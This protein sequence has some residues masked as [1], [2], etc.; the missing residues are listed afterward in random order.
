MMD[1]FMSPN[2]RPTIY[3]MPYRSI[4]PF[5]LTVI[6]L[7]G[8]AWLSPLTGCL[9]RRWRVRY[10][11]MIPQ[12]SLFGAIQPDPHFSTFG[13]RHAYYSGRHFIDVWVWFG[14][15]RLRIWWWMISCHPISYLSYIWCHTGAYFLFGWGLQIFMELYDLPHS[16]DTYQGDDVFVIFTRISHWSLSGAIQLGLHFSTLRCYHASP[17]ERYLLDLWVWFYYGRGWLRPCIW[18]WMIW[19]HLIFRPV[20][21]DA[22]LGHIPLSVDICTSP[23]IRMIILG[24]KIHVRL[25]I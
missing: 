18:W 1:D 17:S 19:G 11:V 9:P 15:R 23:L 13:C 10:L 2:F 12:W 14:L 3:L 5:R 22:I 4:F 20:T 7:Q 21:H 8:V 24:Y 6:D 16:R 25:M